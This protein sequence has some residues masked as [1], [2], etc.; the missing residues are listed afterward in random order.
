[1]VH[2]GIGVFAVRKKE[3]KRRIGEMQ[4]ILDGYRSSLDLLSQEYDQKPEMYS[5]EDTLMD[6]TE[7]T[8]YLIGKIDAMKIAIS[9]ME[10]K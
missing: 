4:S 8:E 5:T 6:Y 2:R 10:R 1:M 7:R 3:V 9:I